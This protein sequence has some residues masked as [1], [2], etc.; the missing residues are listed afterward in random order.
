M[1]DT[2]NIDTNIDENSEEICTDI[3]QKDDYKF[4]SICKD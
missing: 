3:L 4:L 1:K 2:T